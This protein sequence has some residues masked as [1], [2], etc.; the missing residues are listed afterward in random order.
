MTR[1]LMELNSMLFKQLDRLDELDI[2]SEKFDVEI[3]RTEAIVKLSGQ[4]VNNATVM[5]D[6]IKTKERSIDSCLDMPE[7]FSLGSKN[8]VKA[9]K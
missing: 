5:L 4:I 9:L 1:G 6:A 3:Q 2:S 7:V 8:A